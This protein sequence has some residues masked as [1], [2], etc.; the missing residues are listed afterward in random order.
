MVLS[1]R[2]RAELSTWRA[3]AFADLRGWLER[4]GQSLNSSGVCATA[5]TRLIKLAADLPI[6]RWCQSVLR[7]LTR[8]FFCW[9]VKPM[10]K[11]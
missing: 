8:S 3:K 5:P 10:P 1:D 4:D 11:R 6:G 9:S 7:K 2:H